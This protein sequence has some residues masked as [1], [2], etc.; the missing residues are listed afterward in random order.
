M[1]KLYFLFS[2]FNTKNKNPKSTLL[3]FT[4]PTQKNKENYRTNKIFTTHNFYAINEHSHT[5]KN[6]M[7]TTKYVVT[8]EV[9]TDH[10]Q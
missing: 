9:E 8:S 2:I 10:R 6:K 7:N 3:S 1:L 4:Y 5:H